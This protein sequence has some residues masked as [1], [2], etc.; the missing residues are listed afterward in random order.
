M[1]RRMRIW[2]RLATI[3]R[4]A[5]EDPEAMRDLIVDDQLRELVVEVIHDVVR[6][7]SADRGGSS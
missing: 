3:A 2:G 5:D 4:W 7:E 6:T 1:A